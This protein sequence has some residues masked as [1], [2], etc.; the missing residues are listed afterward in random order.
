[1]KFILTRTGKD[2][3]MNQSDEEQIPIMVKKRGQKIIQKRMVDL[4][5]VK[6]DCVSFMRQIKA[7]SN[8]NSNL[9]EQLSY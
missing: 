7:T 5:K 8:A 4:R 3:T 6:F 9:L 1:M 2:W